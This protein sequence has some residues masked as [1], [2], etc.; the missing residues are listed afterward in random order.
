MHDIVA[1]LPLGALI[2]LM[3]AAVIAAIRGS[4]SGLKEERHR[5]VTAEE[6]RVARAMCRADGFDPESSGNIRSRAYHDSAA[7]FAWQL[8]VGEARRF[9]AARAAMP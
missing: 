2:L 1:I 8:Y 6:E 3:A 9:L 4:P 5:S 7:K